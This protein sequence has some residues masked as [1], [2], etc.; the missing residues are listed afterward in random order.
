MMKGT[1]M[2]MFHGRRRYL[3]A[4][5]SISV[6]AGVVGYSVLPSDAATLPATGGT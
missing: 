3:F 6:L 4:A 1:S 5:L 2:R